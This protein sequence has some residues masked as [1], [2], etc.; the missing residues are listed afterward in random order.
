MRS[1]MAM[2]PTEERR[3]REKIP[4]VIRQSNLTALWQ[5]ARSNKYFEICDS[6]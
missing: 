6:S 5:T 2:D 3:E 1:E 4:E